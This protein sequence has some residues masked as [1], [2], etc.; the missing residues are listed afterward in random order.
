MAIAEKYAW[1]SLVALGAVF[2]FFQMRLT[3]GWSI[4]DQ[5]AGRLFWAYCVTIGL[6]I[7]AEIIIASTLSLRGRGA[8]LEKD[9]RDVAIELKANQAERVFIIVAINVIVFQLLAENAFSERALPRIDLTRPEVLFFALFT[10]LFAGE[11]VKRIATIWLY[12]A[13]GN[14]AANR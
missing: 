3:D 5:S 6:S 13:P 2:W 7:V 11:F 1:A 9:E 14:A 4:P 8:G 10:A 12:R